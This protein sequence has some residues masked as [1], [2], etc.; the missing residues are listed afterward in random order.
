[1]GTGN[2]IKG[3]GI[4]IVHIA[5]GQRTRCCNWCITNI[6][7][8]HRPSDDTGNY[9]DIVSTGDVDG[10]GLRRA[11][12]RSESNRILYQVA[13]IEILHRRLVKRVSPGTAAQHKSTVSI[14]T[15]G[16]RYVVEGWRIR[17][18]DVTNC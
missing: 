17:I 10:Y 7:L 9:R 14:V 11:I 4:S 6:A 15:G 2:I 8:G 3:W 12:G 1:M 18:I 5:D 16:A 13:G